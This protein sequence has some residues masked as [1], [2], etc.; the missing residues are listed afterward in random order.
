M[1]KA[2]AF[3]L[4]NKI[5][6]IDAPHDLHCAPSQLGFA[7]PRI[8]SQYKG[9][10]GMEER[11]ESGNPGVFLSQLPS[12]ILQGSLVEKSVQRR[13]CTLTSVSRAHVPVLALVSV[14]GRS[15]RV[16][17]SDRVA[18]LPSWFKEKI[19]QRQPSDHFEVL[20]CEPGKYIL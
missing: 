20:T 16:A 12:Q 8:P 15:S 7:Q 5:P 2:A 17:I 10:G 3:T 19:I 11:L 13:P 14:P 9:A 4:E 6:F 18:L 1:R